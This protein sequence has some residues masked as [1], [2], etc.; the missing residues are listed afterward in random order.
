MTKTKIWK[1]K[2]L[3]QYNVLQ[4]VSETKRMMEFKNKFEKIQQKRNGKNYVQFA[5]VKLC[6]LKSLIKQNCISSTY[7]NDKYLP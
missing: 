4:I 7:I 3:I 5:G 6:V 1:L 2:Y